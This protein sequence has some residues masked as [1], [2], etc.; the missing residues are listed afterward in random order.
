MSSAMEEERGYVCVY[1][2]Q[3]L[4]VN[5]GV[6]FSFTYLNNGFSSAHTKH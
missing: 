1:F 4:L 2:G 3:F 6:V 5:F